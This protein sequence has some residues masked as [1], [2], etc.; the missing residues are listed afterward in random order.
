M[1]ISARANLRVAT[2]ADA[3]EIAELF[4]A[5]R[6]DALPYIRNAHSDDEIRRWVPDVLMRRTEV[7]VAELDGRIVGF[8]SVAGESLEHLY[9]L[10]GYFRQGIG[11][12]LL[13]HA[14]I[15]SPRRL[16]LFTF[17]RNA[18]ARAFYEARG[19]V[20]VDLND[21]SRNEE[22]EPDI[23]YKWEASKEAVRPPGP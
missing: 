6:R 20:V 11:D 23:L 15:I 4:I 3:S 5:S 2:L 10:P 8:L 7:W 17:Q 13:A 19:F 14:K 12:R 9:V 21:G 1:S 18:P 16:R 22:H